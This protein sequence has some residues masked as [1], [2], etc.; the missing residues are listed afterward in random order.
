MLW[1]FFDWRAIWQKDFLVGKMR[2]E[3][4][5]TIDLKNASCIEWI[6]LFDRELLLSELLSRLWPFLVPFFKISESYALAIIHISCITKLG[7]NSHY[8]QMGD[9]TTTPLLKFDSNWSFFQEMHDAL[10]S[11][12]PIKM[13][14]KTYK[15]TDWEEKLLKA[16]EK[17]E[18][19]ISSCIF[20]MLSSAAAAA[21]RLSRIQLRTW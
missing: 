3:I 4:N 6:S 16:P 21:A 19:R 13:V 7:W 15:L 1:I 10:G 12:N 8:S 17:S 14:G 5:F 2:K 11:L 9:F 18:C 20:F